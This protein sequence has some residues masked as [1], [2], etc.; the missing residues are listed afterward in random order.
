MG[1]SLASR[2]IRLDTLSELHPLIYV[3]AE[4]Q[5]TANLYLNGRGNNMLKKTLLLCLLFVAACGPS[6]SQVA[7]MQYNE[8]ARS[9]GLPIVIDKIG[10]S[11]PNSAGGVD[12]QYGAT[13]LSEKT[14]KY[15]TFTG[16][17]YNA[18]GD[19]VR[20]EIRRS[21]SFSCK[22]TGP[23]ASNL[24]TGNRRCE[25][26][27]YNHTI[28]CVKVTRVKITYMDNTTRNFTS[29]SSIQQLLRPS[30]SN[31]CRG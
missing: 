4:M 26:A 12:F 31:S 23:Y 10:V 11:R 13:N 7:F 19:R 15:L 9:A 6:P 28:Q 1:L 2:G 22:D 29:P 8:A 24:S 18:V 3:I 30:V 5:F 27:W 25:N 14:I 16:T 17:P 21:S 20:G